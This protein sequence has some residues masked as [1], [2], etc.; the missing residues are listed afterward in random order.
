HHLPGSERKP[1]GPSG[2]HDTGYGPLW[3]AERACYHH[4]HVRIGRVSFYS[5]NGHPMPQDD[6]IPA[7]EPGSPNT[8]QVERDHWRS[9]IKSGMTRSGELA[10]AVFF[11]AAPLAAQ[12]VFSGG[13]ALDALPLGA[14]NGVSN[15][16]AEGGRL[17]AGPHLVV[18]DDGETF[19][20][21]DDEA[22]D[23]A[24]NGRPSIFSIDVEGDVIWVGLGFRDEDNLGPD[25]Q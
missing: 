13:V 1:R 18:T 12:P 5:L 24:V 2:L 4:Y 6:V 16:H 9:R 3:T 10:L 17:Y 8:T 22:L 20:F 19:T 7:S 15:L 11:F 23:P 14:R 25:G 21:F